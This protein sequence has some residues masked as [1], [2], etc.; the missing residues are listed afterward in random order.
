M[1]ARWG[2][3]EGKRRGWAKQNKQSK[4]NMAGR[5]KWGSQVHTQTDTHTHIDFSYLWRHYIDLHSFLG[6]LS[7]HNHCF[8][9]LTLTTD[10]KISCF[11]IEDTA[12]V[13]NLAKQS[14]I[15][16]SE[17]CP[18]KLTMSVT[19]TRTHRHNKMTTLRMEVLNDACCWP[20]P[21]TKQKHSA[22]RAS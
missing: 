16:R 7:N 10:P 1:R 18:R 21:T 22:R 20:E 15:N 6:D 17:I 14:P 2:G 11:P 5:F 13:P 12:F 19:R 8:L 3:Q 4:A 9:T